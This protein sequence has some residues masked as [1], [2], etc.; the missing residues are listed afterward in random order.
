MSVEDAS[1]TFSWDRLVDPIVSLFSDWVLILR[2]AS[3]LC[4]I[5]HSL[6]IVWQQIAL[7]HQYSRGMAN[8]LDVVVMALVSLLQ[9]QTRITQFASFGSRFRKSDEGAEQTAQLVFG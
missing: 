8:F 4:L 9:R 2:N 6:G 5:D 1:T 7:I 3:F